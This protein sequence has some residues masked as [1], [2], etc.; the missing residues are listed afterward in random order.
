MVIKKRL[1]TCAGLTALLIATSA[2]SREAAPSAVQMSEVGFETHG[3]KTATIIDP[4]RSPLPW[5]VM[6]ASRHGDGARC[7]HRVRPGRR[8]R[9]PRPHRE[10]FQPA[11]AR[12]RLSTDGRRPRRRAFTVTDRPHAQLKY[13]ALS[14]F[15]QNRAGIPITADHVARPD[16]ARAARGHPHEIA[17][18]FAGTRPARSGRA[19]TTVWTSPA[20]GMTQATTASMSSTPASPSG[21]C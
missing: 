4:A 13:D 9:R 8:V 21:P 3:P 15:Y 16:L 5:R 10:F 14:Y 18:C 19:V 17:T 20:D 2:L 11:D 7:Q 1:L 6:D 12:R